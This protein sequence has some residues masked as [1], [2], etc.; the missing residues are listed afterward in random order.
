MS[1]II[2]IIHEELCTVGKIN[3]DKIYEVLKRRIIELEYE[4]GEVLNEIDVA[5]EFDISRTPIRKIFQ[6]LSNDKLLNIIPR[7][8]AQVTPID[9]KYM[10]SVFEVTRILDPYAARLATER[11]S[12]ENIHELE[13]IIHRLESYDIV[14]D[15]QE[16]INDDERFHNIIFLSSEN[17]CL[18]E[19]LNGLHIHT[20]RLWHYSEQY[21]DSMDIF[22]DT[23]GE[24]LE[25]IKEKDMD[26]AEKYAR[27][28]IDAFVEKIKQEML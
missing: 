9:F 24:V 27:E 19:V 21:I 2:N 25:A 23:L 11:I 3:T 16:A 12:D 13:T 22:T 18:G 17:P 10:K 5:N 15:Y 26:M 1:S 4:P 8:G 28:H 7:F 6:Q 14:E 20:E